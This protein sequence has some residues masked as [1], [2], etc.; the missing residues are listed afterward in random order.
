MRG[1]APPARD[2]NFRETHP[3]LSFFRK[4]FTK[5]RA[6]GRLARSERSSPRQIG[7]AVAV[8]AFAGCT[9]AVGFH[10]GLAVALASVFRLNRLWAFVG[11]RVS[12][13]LL[14]PWIVLAE[15]E[16]AHRVRTGAFVTLEVDDVLEHGSALLFDWCLGAVPVGL[17][18]AA[19][20]GSLAYTWMRFRRTRAALRRRTSGS[21][22]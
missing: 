12:N 16:L 18:V 21:T 13:F 1:Y 15:I 6:I 2:T 10:G 11:S 19:L 3:P 7:L 4:A 9:P 22:R 20:A 5:L 8:G 14:L 17:V